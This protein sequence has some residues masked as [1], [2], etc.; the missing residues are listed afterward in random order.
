MMATH[1]F[2]RIITVMFENQ[3]RSYAMQD[4]FLAK[5]ARA[6]MN[7]TNYFGCFH[8]SQTNYLAAL[9][10]EVC[11]VTNDQAPTSPLMQQT[12]VDLMEPAGVSWKAYME[13]Y[14]PDPWNPL[15]A[16]P[17]YPIKA[18]P[19]AM[20]PQNGRYLARYFRKHNAFASFH[21]I[22]RDPD[23]WAKITDDTTFWA[24]VQQGNLPDYAWFTP[25]IWN[26]G[27]YLYN[28][29]IDTNPRQQ[30]IPQLSKWLEYVFLGDPDPSHVQGAIGTKKIGLNLDIDLLLTDPAQA[31]AGSRVP[32]RT[33][34]VITFD[35][36]DYDAEGYDTNYDGPNQIYTVLLG[37]MIQPNSTCDLPLNHYSAIRTVEK[38]FGL[39][40][41]G[42]NDA[43][44]NYVRP[45]WGER[46]AWNAPQTLDLPV[47]GAVDVAAI[48]RQTWMVYGTANGLGQAVLEGRDWHVRDQ[49]CDDIPDR[50]RL[51]AFGDSALLVIADVSGSMSARIRT[52]DV[53][54]D[55]A[56][57]PAAT[58][59]GDFA[60]CDYTTP[61]SDAAKAMLVWQL[62]NGFMQSMVLDQAGW[63]SPQSVGQLTDGPITLA[64]FG[65]ALYLVYK[66]RN[67]HQMRMTSYN[68]AP[69]NAL[70]ARAHNGCRAPEN[71]T[72]ILDW[73]ARD[74]PVGHFARKFA[75]L[76]NDYQATGRL[77]LAAID[78]EMRLIHRGAY[79]DTPSGYEEVF[80]LTGVMA[81]SNPYSNG[82][83][84]LDQAGWTTEQP[85]PALQLD[86]D[87]CLTMAGGESYVLV[88]QEAGSARFHWMQGSNSRYF[89]A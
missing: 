4:P 14:S 36:A 64:Q 55:P 63:Q 69:F 3:Y 10:G 84:T 2:D 44:A 24:D 37:D 6:G 42:K 60:V 56:P 41:L 30:L 86:L 23:R 16:N 88:W 32:E 31:W 89:S 52:D 75:A 49:I 51:C 27:H 47:T 68:L 5:L 77:A 26:D 7:M 15:W 80:G 43:T 83:G 22:Q 81:A 61:D 53:W 33:L 66:E 18:A 9:A 40:D 78:G 73:A 85:L 57:I 76:Q 67:S 72:S 25:D 62:P 70:K 54:S 48:K 17:E 74:F 11:G 20:A 19:I 79:S 29:H 87:S 12:L 1:P 46:F 58:T 82:F 28:T 21:S 34:I 50:L 45:L 65:P 39:G 8:P 38:N 71:D 13:A 59:I 35:E